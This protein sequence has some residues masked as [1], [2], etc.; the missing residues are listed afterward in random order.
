MK[1]SSM[2]EFLG[3]IKRR[4]P[5]HVDWEI[6]TRCPNSCK[7][8][9]L[10]KTES[11]N[12]VDKAIVLKT[13]SELKL[14]GTAEIGFTGGDPLLYDDFLSILCFASDL[15][16]V[17][18]LYLSG[19][20]VTKSVAKKIKEAHVA[21]VEVTFLGGREFT[22][23]YLTGHKGAYK[24][25]LA[26]IKELKAENVNILAKLMVTKFSVG[27]I[28]T[29]IETCNNLGIPFQH[30]VHIW[31]PYHGTEDDVDYLRLVG[32][33]LRNYYIEYGKYSKY[34]NTLQ[35]CTA[36]RK[37]IGIMANGDVNPCGIYAHELVVGNIKDERISDIW[38]KSEKLMDFLKYTE[39]NYPIEKCQNCDLWEYC[40]LCPAMSAWGGKKE[41]EPYDKVCDY[42]RI[43]K[44]IG[45]TLGR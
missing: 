21:K 11:S 42:S 13:I 39:H 15:G 6:T 31:R 26:C 1:I 3:G 41:N 9:Y 33:E 30:D 28:K 20:N 5:W 23:D 24:N 4:V 14:L 10:M 25:L 8:C 19:N 2:S 40:D 45:E 17:P 35:M 16:I 27:E 38:S 12:D 36:G 43:R 22:H 37:K 18:S 32:A 44:E 34:N 29:F 7:H